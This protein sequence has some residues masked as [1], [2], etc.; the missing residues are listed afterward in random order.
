MDSLTNEGYKLYIDYLLECPSYYFP[1][2][3]LTATETALVIFVYLIYFALLVALVRL[4]FRS[5]LFL[6]LLL[7]LDSCLEFAERS[8]CPAL[9]VSYFSYFTHS[10]SERGENRVC[11]VLEYINRR[12]SVKHILKWT[13]DLCE[14]FE[15][16]NRLLLAIDSI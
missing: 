10:S 16:K 8:V 1:F 4:G 15:L 9:P 7:L 6:A 12:I 11:N 3:G 14:D 5:L 2:T 13:M